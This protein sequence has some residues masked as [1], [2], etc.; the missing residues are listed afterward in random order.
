MTQ[1]RKNQRFKNHQNGLVWKHNFNH[2]LKLFPHI[3]SI[4]FYQI[5]YVSIV[6]S[7]NGVLNPFIAE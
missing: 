1:N 6:C 7:V 4:K 2:Q 5:Q 3:F